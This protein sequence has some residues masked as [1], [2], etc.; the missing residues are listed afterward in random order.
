MAGFRPI[1]K[2]EAVELPMVPLSECLPI[3]RLTMGFRWPVP[4]DW[5]ARSFDLSSSLKAVASLDR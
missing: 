3:P 1:L 5:E 4:A 2:L